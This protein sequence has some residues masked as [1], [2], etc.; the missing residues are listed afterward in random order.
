MRTLVQYPV[1]FIGRWSPGPH[2]SRS[3][4][5]VFKLHLLEFLGISTNRHTWW[6]ILHSPNSSMNSWWLTV[7]A[8]QRRWHSNEHRAPDNCGQAAGFFG[9][10]LKKSSSLSF[11]D[12][13]K[14]TEG[15]APTYRILRNASLKLLGF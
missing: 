9:F 8:T 5:L 7:A 2:S 3:V 12:N 15:C 4:F 10:T 13:G 11:S 14:I 1:T 6:G